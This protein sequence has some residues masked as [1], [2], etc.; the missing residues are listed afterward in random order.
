MF[1][2]V[3]S[4]IEERYDDFYHGISLIINHTLLLTVLFTCLSYFVFFLQCFILANALG[5]T[6]DYVTIALFMAMSN[7][8]SFIPVSVS[9]L[10]TRDATLI[11]LFALVGLKPELAVSCAFLVFAT[12]FVCG[13]IFGATAWWIK[14]LPQ[15]NSLK[16]VTL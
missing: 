3:K 11:F 15:Y 12:F 4:N 10:G 2:I 6:I 16:G 5:L 14:P 1:Q 7:L 8:I 9:G 13:G